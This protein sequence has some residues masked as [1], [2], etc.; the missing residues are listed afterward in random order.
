MDSGSTVTLEMSCLNYNSTI[1]GVTSF[2]YSNELSENS[3]NTYSCLEGVTYLSLSFTDGC[4]ATT[5]VSDLVTKNCVGNNTC[6]LSI[7]GS[8]LSA[9]CTEEMKTKSSSYY[10]SYNCYDK[11][12]DLPSDKTLNRTTMAYIVV[13]IDIVSM[14]CFLCCIFIIYVGINRLSNRYYNENIVISN[15]TLHLTD[16]KI[17]YRTRYEELSQLLSHFKYILIKHIEDNNNMISPITITNYY[18]DNYN[19]RDLAEKL[20]KEIVSKVIFYEINFPK[21][22]ASKLDDVIG[23][24]SLFVKKEGLLAKIRLNEKLIS[25][26][27]LEIL[28]RLHDE[29]IADTMNNKKS[30]DKLNKMSS[31]KQLN[32]LVFSISKSR[33]L[34][35][36]TEL[37]NNNI[38]INNNI[39]AV[40]NNLNTKFNDDNYNN[41]NHS[42]ASSSSIMSQP[43]LL[44]LKY[45][46]KLN[47]LKY[48][49]EEKEKAIRDL[50]HSGEL[51]TIKEVYLTARNQNIARL[52]YRIYSKSKCDRFWIICCCQKYKIKHL[53]YKNNWL[54]LKFARDEPSNIKWQ[55]V[56]YS[57]CLRFLR[58]AFSYLISFILII[59]SFAIIIGGKYAQA[60]LYEDYNLNL[61]CSTITATTDNL[62]SEYQD[63]SLVTKEK[64]YTYCFCYNYFYDNGY[65]STNDFTILTDVYPC[66]DWLSAYIKMTALNILTIILVPLINNIIFLVLRAITNFERNKTLSNDMLSNFFKIFI[67]QTI[68]TGIVIL[69]VN[70]KN[71]SVKRNI[72]DF[73]ILTGNYD[74]FN[75]NWFFYVGSLL[76]SII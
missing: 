69:L 35:N 20:S 13:I 22:N 1:S 37:N 72:P 36:S 67:M 18:D 28:N 75:P 59:V 65:S 60:T 51:N 52:F 26:E 9:N 3:E 76:V 71:A 30:R 47:L 6:S 62:I 57:S 34:K 55:N 16:V 14:I 23:L 31:N 41:F 61:D 48:R 27:R 49:I 24:N 68:N 54:N 45:R 4:D 42:F 64:T 7:P 12:I 8:E 46:S 43:E 17:P 5:Y 11:Y 2:A 39:N 50:T 70:I 58:S 19:L 21:L 44:L 66:K 74:D 38:A 53:Y 10:F 29:V 25:K 73:P 63:K 32:A 56:A 15:F 40:N 33:S